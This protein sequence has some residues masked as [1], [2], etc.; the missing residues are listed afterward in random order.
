MQQLIKTFKSMSDEIRLRILKILQNKKELCVCQI[1]QA[2]DISQTRASRN[3]GILKDAGFV[4]ARREGL[5]I[6]YSINKKNINGYH[7]VLSKFLKNRLNDEKI[8][9]EDRKRLKKAVRMAQS[10]NSKC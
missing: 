1:T 4:N 3:L 8:I 2:L 10:G 6:Y 7:L 9:K 5:W